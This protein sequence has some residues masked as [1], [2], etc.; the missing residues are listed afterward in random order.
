MSDPADRIDRIEATVHALAERLT[1]IEKRLRRHDEAIE[2]AEETS[3]YIRDRKRSIDQWV[4]IQ[5]RARND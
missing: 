3:R 2:Q 4:Q 1:A 5:E